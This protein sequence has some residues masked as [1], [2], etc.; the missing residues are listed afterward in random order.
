MRLAAL[1]PIL[2]FAALVVVS[3]F[4][5]LRGEPHRTVTEGRIGRPAPNFMLAR[6]D[7]GAPVTPAAFAGRAYVINLFA[8]WCTPCRS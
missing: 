3:S 7:G 8:S 2:L 4:V 5:L 6:L 1:I